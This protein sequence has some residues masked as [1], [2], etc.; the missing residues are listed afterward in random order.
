M[1]ISRPFYVKMN[2][3]PFRASEVE[4]KQFFSDVAKCTNVNLI[5]NPDGRASGDAIAEF[6]T[7][8][9]AENA[10]KKNREHIGNRF[11]ILSRYYKPAQ[12]DGK[13][14]IRMSGLSFKATEQD[15]RTFFGLAE[16]KCTNIK[17]HTIGDGRPSGEAVAEF[18]S[19]DDAEKAM[20]MNRKNIQSR[21]VILTREC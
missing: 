6:A 15:I 8:Q 13:F 10:L 11:I 14:A 7:E 5:K 12:Q 21:F 2:G 9:D 19:R 18:G 16:A 3:L 1:I 20:T 4:I 17:I